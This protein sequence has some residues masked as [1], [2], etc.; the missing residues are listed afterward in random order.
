MNDA[1]HSVQMGVYGVTIA[2][3]VAVAFDSV[4]CSLLIGYMKYFVFM[5][6]ILEPNDLLRPFHA[7]CCQRGSSLLCNPLILS[8]S[9]AL[10]SS[11]FFLH[12]AEYEMTKIV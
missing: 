10:D 8:I 3:A 4:H 11:I 12:V 1:T 7:F 5:S 9:L 6:R 2:I